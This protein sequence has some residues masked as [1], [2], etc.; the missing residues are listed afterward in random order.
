MKNS[1]AMPFFLLFDDDADGG[2]GVDFFGFF[3]IIFWL[4][5]W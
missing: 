2:V 1:I 3:I 5:P 4:L